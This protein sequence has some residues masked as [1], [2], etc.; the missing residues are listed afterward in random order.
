MPAA[1]EQALLKDRFALHKLQQQLDAARKAGDAE[2]LA[3]LGARL[4]QRLDASIAQHEA[5]KAISLEIRYPEE[6][7]VSENRASIAELITKHPV[8]IVAGETGSGKTTQLAK[9][10]LDLGR[11]RAGMIAHTQPRRVA[12]SSVAAR[13]AEEL[14]VE[15]GQQ[16]GYQVRFTDY[17]TDTTL[18]KLMT[19]GVLLAEIPHDRY[20]EKYDT[21]IID[22]A[23][24]R[25]LNIDFLLGYLHRIL[26]KR[27]DLKLIITSATID[28]E[29]FSRHFHNAPIITVSG[30]SYPVEM[31][32]RPL[33]DI[34][35]ELDL[36]EAVLHTLEEIEATEQQQGS[37]GGDVLVFLPGEH[38]IRQTSLL[39][40]KA[41]LPHT[42]VLPLYARLSAKEQ[43]RIFEPGKQAGRRV[44]LATNVAE[45]SLTVPGIR[46][47][48]DSGLARMSRYSHRAKVQRLPVEKVSQASANQRAGR[49]G[50]IGP[51]ICYRLYDEADFN[52][53]DAFTQPE[54]QRTNLSAVILQM[55]VMRLG[56]IANFP[57]IEPPDKR[58]INDGFKQLF[59]IAALDD[60]HNLTP[61]G[62]QIAR[63]PID[64]RLARIVVAANQEA[65]LRE[66]LVIVAALS[67][68]D[69]RETPVEKREA[70][71]EKHSRF[72]DNDS[73]FLSLYKL[74]QYIE[75]LRQELSQNQFSKR[76]QKEFLSVQ[77]LREWRET[78]SQLVRI[79][80]R[81]QFKQN[82]D[83]A[84]FNSIH[85]A[86]LSGLLTNIGFQHE[87]K[88][89][90]G[91]RNRQFRLF[92]T[93]HLSRKPPKWVVAGELIETSQLF[94]HHVARI[95]PAWLESIARHLLKHSYTEPHWSSRQGQVMAYCRSSLY[96][97]VINDKKRV[98]FGK[99]DPQLAHQVF[100]RQALV[101]ENMDTKARF[102]Q[103]N[104]QLRKKLLK[105]EEKSRRRDLLVNDDAVF[106]FYQAR[107][108]EHIVN[109]AGFEKWLEQA[110]K[111]NPRL[112][113]ADESLF[114]ANDLS[115]YSEAQ[116]PNH[117]DMNGVDFALRYR[118]EPGHR[119]DGVSVRVP[120]AA[121]NRVPR[122]RFEWLVPG[123]L[124]DKCEA[125]IKSLP[126]QYRRALV[127]VP[128][129]VK[130]LLPQL[131][132]GD[133]PL[134]Q[135]LAE[136]ITQT[137]G[138]K[139]PADAWQPDKLEDYYRINY[140]LLDDKGRIVEESRD[141]ALLLKKHGHKVQQALDNK[142]A[143]QQAQQKFN[144]WAFDDL[145]K[146]QEFKQA[147]SL[148]KS[149]PAIQDEGDSVSI[150]LTDYPHVQAAVHRQ[151]LIRL[152]MLE[153]AQQTKYLRKEL[154]KGNA[155]QLK[156]TA[157][158]DRQG[159]LEDLLQAAFNHTFF[160]E[161]Q[162]FSQ[163]GY[164]ALLQKH[165]AS[166]TAKAMEL[167]KLL[168][169]IVD[170]D[171]SIRQQLLKLNDKDFGIIKADIERQRAGLVYP[172][173]MFQTPI[174]NLF[175]LPRY[176]RALRQRLERLQNQLPKDLKH[177]EELQEL[178]AL[179][180]ELMQQH[181]GAE[182]LPEAVQYR[183]MLEEYRVSLF[184]Q[185]L[186]T[187][188][189]VSKKR[190]EKQWQQV[191]DETRS[192][193]P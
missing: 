25:S 67:I 111:D 53:R 33:Q 50:R 181:Q 153:L 183:W 49:C 103:H 57:F 82:Q 41:Q 45:T 187:R 105:I 155:L 119:Q 173:F 86:L 172:G 7:P 123:M 23:H 18:L 35:D 118:F 100:I 42:E 113:F 147:G 131:S 171:Y 95:D 193:I 73:D 189:P 154:L 52:S 130:R 58:L 48:I 116:F 83:A 133:Y 191:L 97:L 60:R 143:Q 6:L 92:P 62:R 127:P 167:E 104:A 156:L 166:L 13:I 39:L 34:S 170:D 96:G 66:V 8:V 47:V 85:R 12:A 38:D 32:Y 190:L 89:F 126:K 79:C 77:R 121:L 108:P 56:Q 117:I 91:T 76:C 78:H 9:L 98:S 134:T 90:E 180:D 26:P 148:V 37:L 107:I 59:E 144:R 177:T 151:G 28:V 70:A 169:Q 16:V 132:V 1:I 182:A 186:K 43:R 30:R 135:A 71:R 55:Q 176:F 44:I 74:W 140:Q 72:K 84:D 80:Q 11:G 27:P 3:E 175:D 124:A 88:I 192:K 129:T 114:L 162:P 102:Y 149:Y 141:L 145:P 136:A 120:V 158:Y 21:I 178:Q 160:A 109:Q 93:S 75:E 142:V 163:E 24:E 184:A 87:P 46:Y 40:R 17:S 10:C 164:Q 5:R 61:L 150:R 137:H 65:C 51:G 64:P 179:L 110:E 185:Q 106:D 69:P 4:Q 15:L 19:D 165:K 174:D 29:R 63:L 31:R 168:K 20:L 115:G 152:A 125:L 128:E 81:M 94:A 159:L 157:E 68:Q 2:K 161:H 36:A 14:K 188:Y 146:E 139:I 138:Q 101:E 54:I 99:I 22:E 122:F 112:L